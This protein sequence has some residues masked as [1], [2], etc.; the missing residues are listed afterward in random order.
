[1]LMKL[2]Y[3]W[4]DGHSPK[5]I[6]SKTRFEEWEQDD[7]NMS[8]SQEELLQKIGQWSF[9]GSSTQ[10]AQTESSDCILTPQVVYVNPFD[11]GNSLLVLCEVMN[12]D[13]T[14]HE[15][16]TRHKL[17][18]TIEQN[19]N[20]LVIGVEQEYFMMDSRTNKPVGWKKDEEPK[21]QGE[22]YCSVG[23]GVNAGRLFTEQH[24]MMC[25]TAGL[26]LEGINAEVALGQWEYQIGPLQAM[27]CADQLWVSRYILQKIGEASGICIDYNPKPVEGDWNGSGAHINF[28]TEHL[29]TVGGDEYIEEICTVLGDN[30]EKHMESY[31]IGNEKRLTGKHETAKF[32]EFSY[33]ECDRSVSIRIP[34]VTAYNKK[35]HL[36]DRRPASNVDPY[37]AFCCLVESVPRICS[38][39]GVE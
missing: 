38:C 35:G 20:D 15:S 6:R 30:H 8:Y 34:A 9:D 1:M 7:D 11:R 13:G 39:V 31:G 3:I 22:Y 21:P 10:Q 28:S 27:E 32:D 5:N 18:T 17:R 33:G 23:A 24:A 29:R 37:E 14:P 36:E 2:E 12:S 4:L 16:N 26:S 19:D 25:H